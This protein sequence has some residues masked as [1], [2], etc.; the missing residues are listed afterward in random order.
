[1]RKIAAFVT[2]L[3]LGM[4]L[5][6][7]APAMAQDAAAAAPA[8]G[9]DFTPGTTVYDS[10]GAEIG[11]VS[12][13]AGDNVV[14]TLNG[15]PVTLPKNAFTK[16]DK[17]PAIT[18]TLAQLTAAVGQAAAANEQALAAALV[19]GADI[20]GANGTAVLGKVKLVEGDNVVVT[21]PT[22]DVKLAKSAFFVSQAGLAT[23]FT[24]EQ[25]ASAMEQA[26]TAAAADDAAVAAAL[27]PGADV[28]S[29]NGTAVLGQVKS[30]DEQNVVVTAATGDVS[31][32]RSAFLMSSAGL[33]A[34]YTTEQFASAIGQSTGESAAAPD[35]TAEAEPATPEKSA[36]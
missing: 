18:I 23:N 12:S 2:S 32:P 17:G 29:L 19:P 15:N 30:F 5:A 14:I 6:A 3:S 10:E 27:Q 4:A 35:A 9:P 31:L 21:T 22:G 11:P 13:D 33:S 16:T 36:N 34:G 1:M 28:H 25:F 20:H 24:A 26:N 8:D 7:G